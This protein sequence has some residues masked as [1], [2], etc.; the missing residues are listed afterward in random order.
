MESLSQCPMNSKADAVHEDVTEGCQTDAPANTR[1]KDYLMKKVTEF[2]ALCAIREKKKGW[3]NPAGDRFFEVGRKQADQGTR[4]TQKSSRKGPPKG[5]LDCCMAPGA[6]LQAAIK[7]N[8]GAHAL[9]FTFPPEKGGHI[10]LLGCDESHVL[11]L[12]LLDLT[13][14]AADMGVTPEQIPED[15]PEAAAFVPRQVEDGQDSDL[16]ICDGQVL[17]THEGHRAAY[18]EPREARRL[19]L[20]Q[21]VLGLEHLRPGG[22]MIML[23]HKVEAWWNVRLMYTFSKFSHV[24]LFKP[25]SGHAKRSSFYKVATDI[26]SE[27]RLAKKAMTEWKEQWEQATFPSDEEFWEAVST[28][29]LQGR[30]DVDLVLSEFGPEL[31]RLGCEIWKIQAEA[32]EKAP[33]NRKW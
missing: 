31:V 33:F 32:L 22:T 9:A 18:R 1:I 12:R 4:K 15:H 21:L 29:S 7:H 8:Q 28:A 27:H 17:R 11:E 5:I 20:T 30:R 13:M 26:S 19:G 14:L 3:K 10:P 2:V 6:Y 23:L 25:V 16:V 24:Q